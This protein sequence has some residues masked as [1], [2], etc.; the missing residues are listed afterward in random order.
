MAWKQMAWKRMGVETGQ[1]LD[2]C[3]GGEGSCLR[4]ANVPQLCRGAERWSQDMPVSSFFSGK[5]YITIEDA[6]IPGPTGEER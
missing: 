1:L 4:I 2:G 3:E 5:T 6:T